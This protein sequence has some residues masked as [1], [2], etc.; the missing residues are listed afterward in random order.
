VPEDRVQVA[1]DVR[2]ACCVT[3][4]LENT[5]EPFSKPTTPVLG[6]QDEDICNTRLLPKGQAS[7][8]RMHDEGKTGIAL[9]RLPSVE[10][11]KGW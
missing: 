11:L 10:V 5:G 9:L 7:K 6:N 1:K 8:E 4:G 3:R 2:N